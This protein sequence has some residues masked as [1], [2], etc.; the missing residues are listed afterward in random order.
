MRKYREAKTYGREVSTNAIAHSI[1]E[2]TDTFVTLLHV[3]AVTGEAARV[4][5]TADLLAVSGIGA[6][7]APGNGV[8][9]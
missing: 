7:S 3:G 2:R 9:L 1:W 5:C 6:V 4:I 8:D